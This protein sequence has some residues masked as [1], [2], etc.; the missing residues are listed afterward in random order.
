MIISNLYIKFKL[1]DFKYLKL[2]LKNEIGIFFL[3][4]NINFLYSN[5]PAIIPSR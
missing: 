5:C 4:Q 1:L 3:E 2:K